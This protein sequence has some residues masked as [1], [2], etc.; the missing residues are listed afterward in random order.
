M[1]ERGMGR[2]NREVEPCSLAKALVRQE[3]HRPQEDWRQ[4]PGDHWCRNLVA[5]RHVRRE[6]SDN[7]DRKM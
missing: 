4:D 3:D 1:H 5:L 6:P 2:E 7:L